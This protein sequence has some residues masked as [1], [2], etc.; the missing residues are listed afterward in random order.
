MEQEIHK[1]VVETKDQEEEVL[2][3]VVVEPLDL[4]QVALNM[5]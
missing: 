2:V 5:A 4:F 1:F 3:V